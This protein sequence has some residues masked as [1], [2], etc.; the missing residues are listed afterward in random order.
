MMKITEANK[1]PSTKAH[2]IL[3][4]RLNKHRELLPGARLMVLITWAP[5]VPLNWRGLDFASPSLEEES[6]VTIEET[7]VA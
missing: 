7:Q 2:L 1:A 6:L 4:A 5:K 3:Q